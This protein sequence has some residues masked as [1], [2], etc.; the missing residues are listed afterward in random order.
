MGQ[1]FILSA[2]GRALES[3][4]PLLRDRAQRPSLWNNQASRCTSYAVWEISL[5]L[6]R[7]IPVPLGADR[8]SDGPIPFLSFF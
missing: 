6:V 2:L 3:M 5:L 1:L 8:I 4:L 7:M